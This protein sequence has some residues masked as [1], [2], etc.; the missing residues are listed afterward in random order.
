MNET[1]PGNPSGVYERIYAMVRRVPEGCVATYGQ[2]AK[3]AGGCS[4]RQV[5]YALAALPEG[6]EVPWQRIINS[7]G[8][9]S[10]RSS[11]DNHSAQRGLLE[12]EGI[13][14]GPDGRID[15]RVYR[16]GGV[17]GDSPPDPDL[18]DA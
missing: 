12:D 6:T 15:L 4:A 11:G 2:I 13:R 10:V 16:W 5:G 17:A 3:L 8:H 14:F 9:I 18:F 1:R 7:G